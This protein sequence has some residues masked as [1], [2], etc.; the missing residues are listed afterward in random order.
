M[1]RILRTSLAEKDLAAIWRHVADDSLNAA[2]RLV[3]RIDQAF[4][5]LAANPELGERMEQF[6]PGL[7]AWTVGNYVIYYSAT[8]EGIEVYRVLH[9]ARRRE[10]LL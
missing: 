9:A 4:K 5:T 3:D 8:D 10:D 6:R 2:D 7:R 1:A